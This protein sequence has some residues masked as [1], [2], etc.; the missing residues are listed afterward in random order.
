MNTARWLFLISVAAALVAAC[1][2]S[3]VRYTADELRD[4]PPAVQERI[5]KGEVAFGMTPQEVRYAWG[6]PEEVRVLTPVGGKAREEWTYTKLLGVYQTRKLLFMD[7]KL[8]YMVPEPDRAM[9][10]RP[11]DAQGTHAEPQ[12]SPP[13]QAPKE[14]INLQESPAR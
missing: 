2:Q 12:A 13:G 3:T 4:F 11:L 14:S 1:S 5:M 9:A 10:V 6:A 7:G 8:V